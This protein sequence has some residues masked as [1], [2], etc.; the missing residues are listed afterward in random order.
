[1]KPH[2]KQVSKNADID[3]TGRGAPNT[4]WTHRNGKI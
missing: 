2:N 4:Q 3:S 1:M